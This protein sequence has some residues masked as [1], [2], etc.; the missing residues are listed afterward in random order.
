MLCAAGKDPE[1]ALARL[2]KMKLRQS[3]A[4]VLGEP[5]QASS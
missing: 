5:N 3:D 2:G 1:A 4:M